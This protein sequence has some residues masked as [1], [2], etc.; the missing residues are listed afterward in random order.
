M[1]AFFLGLPRAYYTVPERDSCAGGDVQNSLNYE[2]QEINE[3]K[4]LVQEASEKYISYLE[5]AADQ[6]MDALKDI[7]R[8]CTKQDED[9]DSIYQELTVLS[10]SMLQVCEQ[11]ED[12]VNDEAAIK[13]AQVAFRDK[14]EPIISK[15]YGASRVRTWPQ[16]YQGDYKTIEFLYRNTPMSEGIGY[17]IDK[18]VLSATLA[19]GVRERMRKLAELLK[20]EMINRQNP[21]VLD[22]ACGSCREL[23][24]IVPEIE[25]AR[26]HFKCIDLDSDALD[27]A[28]NRLSYAGLSADRAEFIQYNALRMFDYETA[29]SAFGMQDIIYSVGYFD[30]LADDFLMKLLRT[31][32]MLLNPGGKLIAAF[33]DANRYRS[34]L[35]HWFAD[36]NGFLQRTDDDFERLLRRAE[37]PSSALTMTRVKSG[38]IIFY[39]ATKH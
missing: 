20:T 5:A 8:R 33:K 39:I 19:V 4:L 29:L 25:K 28:L 9:T 15:S 16:G 32:Y 37:I 18:Y 1:N 3:S 38:S 10:D 24:E 22:I 34:Q 35:Y 6:Y 14:T 7:E 27:F 23:H 13:T 26:A 21:K 36:W 12:F 30:Y 2:N 31:L 17:Y 11:F